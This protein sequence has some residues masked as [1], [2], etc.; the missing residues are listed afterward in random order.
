MGNHETPTEAP[1]SMPKQHPV[2]PEIAPEEENFWKIKLTQFVKFPKLSATRCT[3]PLDSE[4]I[5]GIRLICLSH[6]GAAAGGAAIYAGRKLKD[7]SWTCNLLSS[8]PRMMKATIPRNELLAVMMM[9]ELAFVAKKSLGS[10]I[11]RIIYLTDSTIALCWM[12][13]PNI[14][15]Q[16][17]TFAR[18]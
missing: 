14:K 3:T 9:A 15:L 10:R 2:G 8:R 5:S 16:A 1:L 11:E 6:A 13:N 12:Q 4:S 17:Y 7:G 18:V